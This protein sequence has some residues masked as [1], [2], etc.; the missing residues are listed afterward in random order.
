MLNLSEYILII[1]KSGVWE[2]FSAIWD[3]VFWFL[4]VIVSVFATYYAY[5]ANKLSKKINEIEASIEYLQ[6]FH[7]RWVIFTKKEEV[8]GK[9]KE[10]IYITFINTSNVEW[11]IDFIGI[12]FEQKIKKEKNIVYLFIRDNGMPNTT[13]ENNWWTKNRKIDFPYRILPKDKIEI[14]TPLDVYQEEIKKYK[15]Q[16]NAEVKNIVCRFST[17]EDYEY[18]ISEEY[19][20][21]YW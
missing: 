20:K 5:R 19:I 8:L 10:F 9:E 14:K 17:W 13:E 2:K 3:I 15:K 16:Y 21:L 18:S 6:V 1:E 12:K 11:V 7:W 4:T